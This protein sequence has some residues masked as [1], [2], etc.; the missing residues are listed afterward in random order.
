[1]FDY[2]FLGSNAESNAE[3]KRTK[4]ISPSF[5]NYISK[6]ISVW[7]DSLSQILR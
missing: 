1:M 4:N 7:V 3:F 2:E 5:F 6:I